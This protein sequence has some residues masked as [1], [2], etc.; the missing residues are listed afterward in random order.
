MRRFKRVIPVLCL[1]LAASAPAAGGEAPAS[2]KGELADHLTPAATRAIERGLEYLA[3]QQAKDGSWSLNRAPTRTGGSGHVGITALAGI[4]MMAN[5]NVPGRGKYGENVL[6]AAEFIV[7]HCDKTTGYINAGNSR[8]YSHGFATLFLAEVY[9]M[10]K[11]EYLRPPVSREEVRGALVRAVKLIEGAQNPQGG[12]RYTPSPIDADISV[13]ICQIMA[14]R[15]ARNVGVNVNPRTIARGIKY[16]KDCQNGDGGFSYIAHQRGGSGFAR[17]AAGVCS[18]Y[19]AGSYEGKEIERGLDYM[20]RGRARATGFHYFYGHYYAAQA[21]HQ[22]GG[23]YWDKYY[24]AIRDELVKSQRRDGSWQK[25]QGPHYG[26]SMAV[27]V[28]SVPNE[29]L[30]I[31]ER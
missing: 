23:K 6:E 26:T 19:Y 9:G 12:W 3:A 2:T 14:L 8:M 13:T 10:T 22:A 11:P 28:L 27:I 18:L 1:A 29:Y 21:M 31:F 17:T 15:S 5:G 4:A 7:K 20:H 24:P 30:P 25:S 16:V